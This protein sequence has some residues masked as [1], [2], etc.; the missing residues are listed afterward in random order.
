MFLLV[1]GNNFLHR[2]YHSVLKNN[3]TNSRGFPTGATKVYVNMIISLEKNYKDAQIAFVFD[4]KGKSFRHELYNDYKATRKP[5]DEDLRKQVGIIKDI[6]RA[7]GYLIIEVPNVEADDVIGNNHTSPSFFSGV[8][9]SSF[10]S[11]RESI[12]VSRQMMPPMTW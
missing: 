7:M 3:F 4:A 5:M 11:S 6:I 9:S 12:M 8:L 2:A 10:L 1:D